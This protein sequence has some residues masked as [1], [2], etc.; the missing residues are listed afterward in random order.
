MVV[1][2]VIVVVARLLCDYSGASNSS[3][4]I[5][6]PSFNKDSPTIRI[7]SLGEAPAR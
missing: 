1:E 4:T 6:D 7:V 3:L 2:V 5:A